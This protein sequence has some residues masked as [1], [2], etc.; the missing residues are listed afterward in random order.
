MSSNEIQSRN[1][2]YHIIEGTLYIS[3]GALISAQT[4]MPA[5]IKRLGGGDVLIGAWPVVVYLAFFLPQVISANNSGTAQYRKPIVIKLGLIQRLNLLLLACAIAIWGETSPTL[6]LI[7]LFLLFI[8]NQA[9]SGYVSPI[10]MDFLA[11]TTSPENRGRLAGWRISFAAI[12]GLVNGF[13][14]TVLLVMISFPYNYVAAIGLAFFYQISSLVAQQKIVEEQPSAV[15]APVRLSEL[16]A[17]MRFIVAGNRPFRR[18]LVASALLT[19]S[20]SSVA[21]FTVAA[22]KRFDLSESAVGI[23]TVLTI[24]G[25]ILSGVVLGWV[26]DTKGTKSALLIC[27]ISLLLSIVTALFAPSVIWFYFVFVFMGINVGAEMYMRYNF[28][29]ECA[30]EGDRPMYVGIMNAWFAPVY[31]ISPFAGWLCAVHGYNFVFWLSLVIGSAGIILL[32]KTPDLR[33]EK[34]ALSSK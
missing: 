10:W 29:V 27:G 14:L 22:M 34:L 11:K 7:V 25:Q 31:L 33:A 9:T 24:I 2:R 15:T 18:F 20:F 13:I 6:T 8:S 12:L 23:F 28:A 26:A 30:P 21:F 4:I 19:G 16:F 3:T 1:F 32:A 5:L 17:R